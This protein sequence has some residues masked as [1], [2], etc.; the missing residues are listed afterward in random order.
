MGQVNLLKFFFPRAEF[1]IAPCIYTGCTCLPERVSG[2]VFEVQVSPFVSYKQITGQEG[3][4]PLIEHVSHNFLLRF[5]VVDVSQKLSGWVGR[6]NFSDNHTRFAWKNCAATD[7]DRTLYA[8]EKLVGQD[9][10]HLYFGQSLC[11]QIKR[12][13][14]ILYNWG[15]I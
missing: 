3:S 4:V 5:L 9:T 11:F 7:G 6:D 1:T 12:S 8:I 15:Y 10:F 14:A 2:S 13:V